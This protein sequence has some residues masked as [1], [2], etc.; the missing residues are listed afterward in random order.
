MLCL[1]PPAFLE[2]GVEKTTERLRDPVQRAACRETLCKPAG[3]FENIVYGVGWEAVYVSGV[4][5]EKNQALVGKS[6]T[7]IAAARG[8]DPY[9]AAFDLLA[10]EHCNVT[11]VD[12]I[13]CEEDI[14]TIL[15][16]PYTSIISDAVYS[17]GRPHPRN[18]SNI[19]Q[20]FT[21]Y[22][23]RR[24]TL[25]LEEAVH[26]LTGMPAEA[27]AL[28]RKGLIKPGYDADLAAFR[29][30]NISPPADYAEPEKYTTGMDHVFIAGIEVLEKGGPT[31]AAPGRYVAVGHAVGEKD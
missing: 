21:E 27:M 28:G 20:V 17:G 22:V 13:T 26:K 25:T 14:E 12:Y 4:G 31:G 15:R 16:L 5:S 18:N 23:N 9:D 6:I 30:E 3:D 11:M 8:T 24:C 10:E 29:P 7:E 19:A 1:L 2:G